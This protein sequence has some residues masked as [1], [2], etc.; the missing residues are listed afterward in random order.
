MTKLSIIWLQFG[1]FFFYFK[2]Q[3]H[4]NCVIYSLFIS[5]SKHFLNENCIARRIKRN[6]EK[7]KFSFQGRFLKFQA[8]YFFNTI[9]LVEGKNTNSTIY[10]AIC[11]FGVKTWYESKQIFKF[12]VALFFDVQFALNFRHTIFSYSDNFR[13]HLR[14][15]LPKNILPSITKVHSTLDLYKAHAFLVF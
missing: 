12:D 7:K 8:N 6:A 5:T 4:I 15:N 14:K 13:E 10:K 9:I 2:V 3:R 11:K 1:N